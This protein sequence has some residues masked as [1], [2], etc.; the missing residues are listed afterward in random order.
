MNKL[1]SLQ[2]PPT[3][4]IAAY[5]DIA[6]GAMKSIYEHGLKIPEDISIISSDD[7][8]ESQYLH[9]RLTSITAYNEDLAEIAVDLLFDLIEKKTATR[10]KP[11]RF[12]DNL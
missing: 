12:Q 3:A 9:E 8:K 4:V 5:D 2:N 7:R 1:L 10:L 11:L 6:F